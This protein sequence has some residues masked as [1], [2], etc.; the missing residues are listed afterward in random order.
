MLEIKEHCK[1]LASLIVLE[2]ESMQ[3]VA[4]SL[5]GKLQSIDKFFLATKRV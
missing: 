2:K 4:C 1:Y 3:L 5:K